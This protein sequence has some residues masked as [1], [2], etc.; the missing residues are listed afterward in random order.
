MGRYASTGAEKKEDYDKAR[1]ILLARREEILEELQCLS[2][3][4][5]LM[6]QAF[7]D[8]CDQAVASVEA[9]IALGIAEQGG[10]ELQGI[11]AALLRIEEGTYGVCEDCGKRIDMHRLRALP[12]ALRCLPCQLERDR[13]RHRRSAREA[14]QWQEPIMFDGEGEGNTLYALQNPRQRR[15]S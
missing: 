2:G 9:D 4:Q 15:A 6:G 12:H 3:S 1:S 10:R 14:R 11:D 5:E 7:S 8:I 13:E